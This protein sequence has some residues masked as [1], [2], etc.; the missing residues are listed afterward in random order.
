MPDTRSEEPGGQVEFDHP[1]THAPHLRIGVPGAAPEPDRTPMQAMWHQAGGVSGLIYSSIP[2]LIFVGVLGLYSLV[3]ALV[4]S[5]GASGVI[6]I[7]RLLRRDSLQPAISGFLSVGISA[8]VAYLM[9]EAR[10]Y[11]LIGIWANLFWG[12]VFTASVLARRPI[13][14]YAWSWASGTDMSWRRHPRAVLAYDIATIAWIAL[15]FT[16]F[17]VQEWLYIQNETTL[18]GGT[19]VAMGWPLTAVGALITMLIIRY[20]RRLLADPQAHDPDTA[21]AGSPASS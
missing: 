13:V 21:G 11:F 2:V 5:L 14:G 8:V 16:R 10:G 3:P 15:F 1:D 20:V 6:L 17:G 19:K 18:L 9:G 7:W 12:L 4:A